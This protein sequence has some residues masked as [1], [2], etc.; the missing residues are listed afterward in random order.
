MVVFLV[1]LLA[2]ALVCLM[3]L[4]PKRFL[5]LDTNSLLVQPPVDNSATAAVSASSTNASR[6]PAV[7]TSS[8]S[9]PTTMP[10]KETTPYHWT[11]LTH[12]Y[13]Y[14][15]NQEDLCLKSRGK[16]LVLLIAV[17]SAVVNVRE[18]QAIRDTWGSAC[19]KTGNTG[20]V[21]VVFMLGGSKDPEV[22]DRVRQEA[23]KYRDIVQED[24][25]DSYQNLTHKSVMM[26][27][28]ATHFCPNVQF[29]LKTDDDM[30]VNVAN[31]LRTAS[32]LATKKNI[33]FGVFFRRAVPERNWT[34]KWYVPKSQYPGKWFPDYLSGTA[35][36]MTADVVPKLYHA[37]LKKPFLIM[38]DVFVT[39]ICAAFAGVKR[40]S[41]K[42]FHH[43]KLPST[44]CAFKETI[45]GHHVN[46]AE[47]KKIWRELR[48]GSLPCRKAIAVPKKKT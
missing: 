25:V 21:R 1:V 38:E 8:G 28:W 46:V 26:L 15:V 20:P 34:A 18:R 33:M 2:N 4:Q 9:P 16:K 19:S 31:L 24:F 45:T 30:Y 10:S 27:K 47:M 37:A 23:D 13:N 40:L 22:N 36:A 48:N 41:I 29:V 17:C 43:Y 5:M 39:G 42:G 6:I 12:P 32:R 14:V 7:N 11:K 3:Y 35:Y 44:G